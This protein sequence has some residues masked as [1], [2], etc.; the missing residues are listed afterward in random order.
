[1]DQKVYKEGEWKVF[2]VCLGG[3]QKVVCMFHGMYSPSAVLAVL[4]WP[5]DNLGTTDNARLCCLRSDPAPAPCHLNTASSPPSSPQ[6]AHYH[7]RFCVG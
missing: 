4:V 7:W 5:R 6:A 3:I 1:M 2:K